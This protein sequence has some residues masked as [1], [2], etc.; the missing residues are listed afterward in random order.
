MVS[1]GSTPTF[2]AVDG[3]EG[4]TEARPGVYLFG[5]MSMVELGI[6][7]PDRMALS[8]LAT[9]IGLVA[10]GSTALIDAGWSALSQ[11]RGGS[12]AGRTHRDRR[13]HGAKSR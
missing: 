1:V 5:D 9:V 12:L 13:G 8:V 2:V 7:P 4:V 3:L 11:D 6:F 10:G